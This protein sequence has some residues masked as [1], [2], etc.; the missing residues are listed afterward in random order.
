MGFPSQP[1]SGFL[2]CVFFL[3]PM[4]GLR[5][6]EQYDLLFQG[7]NVRRERVAEPKTNR[8]CNVMPGPATTD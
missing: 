3:F 4:H 7:R 5:R 1:A 6:V 2:G 8:A